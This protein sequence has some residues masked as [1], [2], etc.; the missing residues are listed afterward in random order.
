MKKVFVI[1]ILFLIIIFPVYAQ[2][3]TT[4]KAFDDFIFSQDNYRA[5]LT[6]FNLK[7]GS[8][9]KNPTLSL[10]EEARVSLYDFLTK[11]ND[12]KRTYLTVVRTRT[13]DMTVYSK[14][15]PEVV[16]YEKREDNLKSTDSLEDLLIKSNEEDIRYQ[17]DTLPIIYFSLGNI[18]LSSII[19]LKIEHINLYEKLK[20][21]AGELVELGRADSSLFE[22]W[23][24]D[25]DAELTKINDIEKVTKIE[26]QKIFSADNYQVKKSYEKVTEKLSPAKSNLLQLNKF[27]SELELTI[28]EKR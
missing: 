22:R 26:I 25:I 10:K 24:K 3:L 28:S 6:E 14:I 19:E 12:Y 8:Y 9:Q 15:D 11:R 4:K 21:E 27:I 23:Y 5:S 20:N 17:T 1:V 16:W 13:S 7:K 18:S 2:D